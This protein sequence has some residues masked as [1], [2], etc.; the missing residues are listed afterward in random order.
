MIWV[1][2]KLE[3]KYSPLLRSQFSLMPVPVTHLL[4]KPVLMPNIP[5]VLPSKE[6][7][8]YDLSLSND[9]LPEH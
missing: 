8:G 6:C 2:L 9:T 1:L 3:L 4:S 7:T 5:K